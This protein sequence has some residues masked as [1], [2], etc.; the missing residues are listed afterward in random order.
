MPFTLRL[1]FHAFRG[2]WAGMFIF[3]AGWIVFVPASDDELASLG[4]QAGS[5]RP[6]GLVQLRA[7][8]AMVHFAPNRAA[9]VFSRATDGEISPE[10][11]G[12]LLRDAA[13]GAAIR[14]AN[15]AAILEQQT[16]GNNL[17]SSTGAKF[18]QANP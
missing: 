7:A 4:V 12:M 8:R 14:A 6:V 16:S 9:N 5:E 3:L 11:A 18:I 2:A 10:L 13:D 17:R 1:A 15:N